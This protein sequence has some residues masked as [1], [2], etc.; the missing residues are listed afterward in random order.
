MKIII[1]ADHRGVAL[2]SLIMQEIRFCAGLDDLSIA[3][4]WINVGVDSEQR[5]DYPEVARRACERLL[6][7]DARYAILICAS[8]V[9]MAMAA[10]RFP[11]IYAALCWNQEVARTAYADDGVNVLA[12]SA[13]LVESKENLVITRAMLEA[14]THQIFKGGRYQERLLMLDN[15]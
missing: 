14:W 5:V 7:G 11:Q 4:E 6:A 2:K 9:G 15:Y 13:E 3:I 8:G 10:N 12:L 1:G